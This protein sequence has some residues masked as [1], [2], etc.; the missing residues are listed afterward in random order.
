MTT[1]GDAFRK[2]PSAAHVAAIVNQ[3]LAEISGSSGS[4]ISARMWHVISEQIT[5]SESQVYSFASDTDGDPFVG[6]G[7]IWS[8]GYFFVHSKTNRIVYLSCTAAS[9]YA[10]T[11]IGFRGPRLDERSSPPAVG[12][13]SAGIAS[14]VVNSTDGTGAA[15]SACSSSS[16]SSAFAAQARFA[17]GLL[18]APPPV[19]AQTPSGPDGACLARP[20]LTSASMRSVS[21]NTAGTMPGDA[22]PWVSLP[23]A[24]SG[25]AA[26][27]SGADAPATLAVGLPLTPGGAPSA[28]ALLFAGANSG[29]VSSASSA[30]SSSAS[31]V[32]LQAAETPSGRLPAR[33]MVLTTDWDEDEDEDE[34]I[35][36]SAAAKRDQQHQRDEEDA[37]TLTMERQQSATAPDDDDDD[38]AMSGDG[39]GPKY[40]RDAGD[41]IDGF[42]FS[43]PTA[44]PQ[45]GELFD[46]DDGDA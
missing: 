16:S 7:T 24:Q 38:D 40:A 10:S 36:E 26:P 6:G 28:A 4:A 20:T 9:R 23:I 29:Y 18:A 31:A 32:T 11:P 3:H 21:G 34:D 14:A 46:W 45:G 41:E 12:G 27:A 39:D 22:S 35:G 43:Q 1:R 44:S 25:F 33:G 19:S 15:G 8:F 17:A 13:A 37:D 30:S 42:G 5:L 2:E